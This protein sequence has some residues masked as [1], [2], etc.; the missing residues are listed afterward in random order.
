MSKD[1]YYDGLYQEPCA[2]DEV[3]EKLYEALVMHPQSTEFVQPDLFNTHL[4][5]K[6]QILYYLEK[7]IN[8]REQADLAKEFAESLLDYHDV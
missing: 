7:T 2:F 5:R 8:V 3:I 1:I 6:E 4:E